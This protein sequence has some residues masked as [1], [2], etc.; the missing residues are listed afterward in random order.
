[1]HLTDLNRQG[2][3]GANSLLLEIGSFRVLVD[4]GLHPKE[5][6][7]EAL[8][9][10]ARLD[11]YALDLILVTHCHL[12]HLGGLPL[13]AR[14][15]PE[16]EIWLSYESS[17]LAPRMMRNSIRVMSRQREEQGVSEYPL[18]TERE[19]R[20]LEDRFHAVPTGR[21]EVFHRHGEEL[22]VEFLHAGHVPGAVSIR[23]THGGQS[24]LFSGDI[25]FTDQRIL[26]GADPEGAGHAD[27][28]VLE[29][30]RGAAEREPGQ[31]RESEVQR[32]IESIAATV[33]AG[34]SVLLPVFALGRMQEIL[35]ILAEAVR[36]RQIPEVPVF[37]SG[38]GMD[39]ANYF[40]ELSRKNRPL[41]FRRQV[42]RELKLQ[43]TPR[44]IEPGR[45]PPG[46]AIYVASSGM[47]VENTPSYQLAA[48]LLGEPG[49]LLAFVGYCDPDAPGYAILQSRPG[50]TLLFDALDYTTVRRARV[51]RFDLSGHADREELLDYAIR[52]NPHTVVLSHGDPQARAWFEEELY[53]SVL[54]TQVIDPEPGV[55]ISL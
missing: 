20:Q 5:V 54:D 27:I 51:E 2:G 25:L 55:R 7:T 47:V 52:V 39:L 29:T 16:A 9:D 11:E 38:L 28:L 32:L 1:M 31:N 46:P 15:H 12:D 44:A 30:T 14:R 42:L 22:T 26:P 6:G 13:V 36:R 43:K 18:Y 19:V 3:I 23:L 53:D 35:T 40:D 33:R 48:A 37:A 4:A 50:E 41:R 49:N 8:P 10:L 21:P 45:P 17:V 24:I 34:G